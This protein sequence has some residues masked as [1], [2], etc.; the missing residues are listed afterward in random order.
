MTD[1][2]WQKTFNA[3]VKAASKAFLSEDYNLMN[4]FSNR[5]M[6]DALILGSESYGMVGFFLK[7]ASLAFTKAKSKVAPPSKIAD[8]QNYNLEKLGKELFKV[9]VDLS[10]YDPI[11]LWDCYLNF[12]ERIRLELITDIERDTYEDDPGLSDH[13]SGWLSDYLLKNK[14]VLLHKENNLLKGIVNEAERTVNVCGVGK[15]ACVFLSIVTAMD[16]TNEYYQFL[17]DILP[18]SNKDNPVVSVLFPLIEETDVLMEENDSTEMLLHANK[19]IWKLIVEWRK[20]FLNYMELTTKKQNILLGEDLRGRVPEIPL[21]EKKRL[22][23]LMTK[24][25]EDELKP[26]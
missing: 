4:I 13:L 24:K 19:I 5:I 17:S 20:L 21:E 6:S 16:W 3:H 10:N 26:K 9:Y 8:S 12:R 7:N 15:M 22:T 14:E 18:F 23:D 25:I 1:Q 2:K 11:P